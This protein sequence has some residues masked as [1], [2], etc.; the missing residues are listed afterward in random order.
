M[1]L[2]ILNDLQPKN[3]N[4]NDELECPDSPGAI[5]DGNLPE[6]EE[7]GLIRLRDIDDILSLPSMVLY[8]LDEDKDQLRAKI[9]L[10]TNGAWNQQKQWLQMLENEA[11]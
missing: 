7:E 3:I 4:T 10:R 1:Y 11:R 9:C 8:D 2:D 6:Q 5:I